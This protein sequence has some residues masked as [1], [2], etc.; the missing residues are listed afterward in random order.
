MAPSSV[1]ATAIQEILNEAHARFSDL[2]DGQPARYIPELAKANP[3]HFGI[4]LATTSGHVY[5][6][7][8]AAECFTI[9]S[10]SK[11]FT[12]AL[13]LKLLPA[14][15]LLQTVGVE[16]SG[17]AF[18]AISLD[19][20]SG[21]PRNPMINAGAI[22]TTAQVMAQAPDHAAA[23]LLDFYS[24]LAG[25]PLTVDEAVFR[26][27]RDSGH[28]N[29]AIGHL[30]RQ[31]GI[32]GSDPEPSLQLYFRQCAVSV[33][34]L[35]LASMAATLACQGRHPRTGVSVIEPQTTT[36]VLAVMGS[37]GM[38]NYAGQW[39]HDVGMPAKSGVAGGL[40]AVVPGRLGLA[41]YSPPLDSLGNSVRGVAVCEWLSRQLDLHLFNQPAPAGRC[42]RSSSDGCRRH[43]RRWRQQGE[44]DWLDRQGARL[45]LLEVQGVLD[46][47]AGE[48][49]LAEIDRQAKAGSVLVLDLTR[50][51]SLPA[52]GARLMRQQLGSLGPRHSTVLLCM[53]RHG[54]ALW[55]EGLDVPT[56]IPWLQTFSSLDEA[57]EHAEEM[58]LA[59]RP[60][61]AAPPLEQRPGLLERL[62][63]ASRKVLE[64]L[65]QRRR[66]QAGELA[67]R[68][69][70]PG[71]DLFLIESGRFSV[72]NAVGSD[73][74]QDRL[75][76]FGAGCW[77]GEVAFLGSGEGSADV[78]A[79]APG[80]CLVL[81]R[82]GLEQLELQHPVVLIQLMRLLHGELACK[83]E[84]TNQELVLL[85]EG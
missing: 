69:G 65:L 83:L 32:I 57:L 30:L 37:C 54:E 47:A 71:S 36:N 6:V 23:L 10:I 52:V 1:N 43:S 44:R 16:P 17:D 46:F 45:K 24:S 67:C 14:G 64:P 76:S 8:D 20:A 48:E 61:P 33:S 15:Q 35:D 42:L 81:G 13:A 49:L 70:G 73:G 26:S 53:G 62:P 29:R 2:K 19:G 50:V 79:E 39:L 18:N 60:A 34:C 80:S 72:L 75:A 66:F 31:F 59:E 78:L 38:Y 85:E 55:Q 28:R 3:D 56:P 74:R 63:Q 41:V 84:R 5:S 51:S 25:R 82:A 9:Q 7:G 40:L 21:R 12:Y 58:L 22:A 68:G 77:F 27:E 11:P 4:A